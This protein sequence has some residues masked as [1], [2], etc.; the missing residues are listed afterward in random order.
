MVDWTEVR[1]ISLII[2]SSIGI[3]AL[4]KQVQQLKEIKRNIQDQTITEELVDAINICKEL[5]VNS[6]EEIEKLKNHPLYKQKLTEILPNIRILKNKKNGSSQVFFS[7]ILK[8]DKLASNFGKI[9]KDPID[10]DTFIIRKLQNIRRDA[11]S[12]SENTKF[13]SKIDYL[14]LPANKKIN[15]HL[16]KHI[17]DQMNLLKLEEINK[18]FIKK[19]EYQSLLPFV[20]SSSIRKSNI[21]ASFKLSSKKNHMLINSNLDKSNLQKLCEFG[22]IN[23]SFQHDSFNLKKIANLFLIPATFFA[24]NL[25]SSKRSLA[26]V[27]KENKI[28]INLDTPLYFDV[29]FKCENGEISANK[30]K[31]LGQNVYRMVKQIDRSILLRFAGISAFSCV[32]GFFFFRKFI[33]RGIKRRI[34]KRREQKQKLEERLEHLGER[35]SNDY[36]CIICCTNPRNV[37]QFPCKHMICCSLCFNSMDEVRQEKTK[38]MMCK[39][40]IKKQLVLD[41]IEKE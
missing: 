1:K 27:V 31:I 18:T 17:M 35:V 25:F 14:L 40:E 26:L 9:D 5:S 21:L 41:F 32:L 7:G 16:S 33:L 24:K 13:Q 23:E 36:K 39:Q 28:A 12:A 29:E 34:E 3:L 8:A 19:S 22:T 15:S 11:Q 10:I 2:G 4:Y 6:E 20:T 37:I 38:C 30:V